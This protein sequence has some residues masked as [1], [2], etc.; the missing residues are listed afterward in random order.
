M[1][2]SEQN[3]QAI[4]LEE[5]YRADVRRTLQEPPDRRFRARFWSFLNSQFGMW[6]LSAVIL[7][8]ITHFYARA[9]S[10]A[11]ATEATNQRISDIDIEVH[12]RLDTVNRLRWGDREL[13]PNGFPKDLVAR[14]MLPPGEKH[15]IIYDL[16][17][18]TLRSLIFEL[19]ALVPS[20]ERP[21]VAEA[22]FTLES[23]DNVGTADPSEFIEWL[24]EIPPL[25]W[26]QKL[27]SGGTVKLKGGP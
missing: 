23:F 27:E 3:K 14:V 1:E 24:E 6:L 11:T 16:R 26:R 12:D 21:K 25:R 2:L 13:D 19:H 9:E 10:K 7:G 20:N 4:L 8:V 5:R 17:N 18:R 15:A 22:L